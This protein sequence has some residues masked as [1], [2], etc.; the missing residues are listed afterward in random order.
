MFVRGID[1]HTERTNA[2]TGVLSVAAGVAIIV[3]PKPGLT[4]VAIFL[5]AWLIVIG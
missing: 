3:W 1:R 5:G 2:V 4:A